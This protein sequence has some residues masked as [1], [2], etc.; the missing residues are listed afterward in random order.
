MSDR[1]AKPGCNAL[2][3]PGHP[4][5]DIDCPQ[6]YLGVDDLQDALSTARAAGRL[7]GLEE[8]AAYVDG[9]G[10]RHADASNRLYAEGVK[11]AARLSSFASRM[12]YDL[13]EEVR[14]LKEKP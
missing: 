4:C 1:C 9:S 3:L 12:I 13:A 5:A 6:H 14:A 7:E 11:D 8:A 10:S 2:R